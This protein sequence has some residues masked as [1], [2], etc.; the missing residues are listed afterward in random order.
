MPKVQTVISRTRMPVS[1]I[2]DCMFYSCN[3]IA[4]IAAAGFPALLTSGDDDQRGTTGHM[5]KIAAQIPGSKLVIL[6]GGGHAVFLEYPV[7]YNRHILDFQA[8]HSG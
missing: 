5:E 7:P 1:V 3:D 6:H 8:E 2:R 4:P